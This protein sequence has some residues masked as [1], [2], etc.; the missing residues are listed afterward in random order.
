MKGKYLSVKGL[1]KAKR[2]ISKKHRISLISNV[3]LL[4]AYHKNGGNDEKIISL[5]RTRPVR[6]LSG[7]VNVSVLTKP[8]PCP[9][10]CIFC[11]FQK[12]A[13]KSYLTNEPAV[14]RAVDN[15]YDPERQVITRIKS[16]KIT[17]HPT[18]KIEI[19]I[20]GGTW[21]FYPEKYRREFIKSCFD[22]CNGVKS[23]TLEESQKVN[24]GAK[25]RIVCLSIETRPDFI[26]KEEIKELRTMGVTMVELGIQSTFDD[27]L[28][29]VQRGHTTEHSIKATKLL[30][31]AGFKVC[32]QVMLNLPGSTPEKDF[33]TFKTIFEDSSFRP[34]FLKIYPCLILKEAP[35]YD[36]YKKGEYTPFCDDDVIE[37][38][39]KVKREIIP[40]YVRIQRLFRDIPSN[41]IAGGSK[42]SNMREVIMKQAKE[43]GW[44]CPCIRCREVREDYLPKNK[45]K[46]KK[47]TYQASEGK[48]LFISIEEKGKLYAILRLRISN[49]PIIDNAAIIREVH[50]YGQQVCT[51]KKNGNTPQHK[52]SG[53]ELIGIAE[54]EALK[55]GKKR[56][57]VISG[58]GAREYW[59]SL[60]Y[61][62]EDTYMV[63][64]LLH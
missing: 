22:A 64:D 32:Y 8:F 28:L 27:V 13:P 39:K 58:I 29:K 31:D 4:K 51:G 56:I 47:I 15:D 63:K 35:L 18:E 10:K 5:L 11:P 19:R 55:N 57:A 34:D 54:K 49:N 44:K 23:A 60:G 41:S 33:K 40:P 2:D 12:D 21:S 43:E 16:L 50:T 6:S 42:L 7:V 14:M 53:K 59:R 48:E 36:I 52:G 46:V 25:H 30:K 37:I 26:T 1:A 61:S 38:L 45:A 62:L 20:V 24:E 3:N 9:G 17:G